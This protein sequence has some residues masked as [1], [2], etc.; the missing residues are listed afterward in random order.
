MKIRQ[1]QLGNYFTAAVFLAGIFVFSASAQPE[2]KFGKE[3]SFSPVGETARFPNV[4][5]QVD[6]MVYNEESLKRLLAFEQCS[7][8]FASGKVDLKK[9]TLIGWQVGGDCRMLVETKLYRS[10]KEKLFTFVVKNIYGGCRAGGWRRG[11][12]TIDK[13]PS[14]YKVKFVE[15]LVERYG[16]DQIREASD[17]GEIWT[18]DGQNILVRKF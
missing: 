15:Y 12:F 9:E 5:L 2:E 11:M 10:D 1:P 8:M 16:T 4:C 7:K 13:I 18:A 6:S 14:D 3:I 17:S